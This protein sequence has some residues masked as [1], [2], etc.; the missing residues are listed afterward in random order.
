[1]RVQLPAE[2]SAALIAQSV[3]GEGVKVVSAFQNVSAAHLKNMDE[4]IDCDVLV[5]GDDRRHVLKW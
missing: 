3:L 2:G 4:L 5:T 1:M